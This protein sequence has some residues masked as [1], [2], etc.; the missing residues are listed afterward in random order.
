LSTLGQTLGKGKLMLGAS[1]IEKFV[2]LLNQEA[3]LAEIFEVL[4]Q[5]A[6]LAEI[7]V[8]CKECRG[9]LGFWEP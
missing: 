4:N 5:E 2:E 1:Y 6:T 9:N 7:F 3:T 8:S